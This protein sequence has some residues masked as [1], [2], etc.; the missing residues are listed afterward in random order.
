[1]AKKNPFFFFLSF[2]GDSLLSAVA[3]IGTREGFAPTS[4]TCIGQLC[5]GENVGEKEQSNNEETP[6]NR[7]P[8]GNQW[9]SIGDKI[10]ALQE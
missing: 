9:Y 6:I 7:Y 10:S 2:F 3:D 5:N 4:P 8:K 1:M